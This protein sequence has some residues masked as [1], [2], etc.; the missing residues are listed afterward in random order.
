MRN[1]VIGLRVTRDVDQLQ[2]K[3]TSIAILPRDL[4]K[5]QLSK[6]LIKYMRTKTSEIDGNFEAKSAPLDNPVFEKTFTWPQ[7]NAGD[8]VMQAGSTLNIYSNGLWEFTAVVWTNHT[9]S[10]D[11]WEHSIN[12]F[13][14]NH[15]ILW[16]TGPL[17]GPNHM[18]DDG[19]H[20]PFGPVRGTFDPNAF[21][22]SVTATAQGI[23]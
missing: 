16:G 2:T 10:G 13:D 14:S 3:I 8:C 9:H 12:V 7:I 18:N 4:S 21:N 15:N 19:T 6:P 17:D 23:C 22:A 20:Y 1:L 11:T 5:A